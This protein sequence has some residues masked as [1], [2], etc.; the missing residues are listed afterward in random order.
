[1]LDV[2]ITMALILLA[3]AC[4]RGLEAI[5]TAFGERIARRIRRLPGR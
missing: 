1:M 3:A 5:L 4:Y 2:A